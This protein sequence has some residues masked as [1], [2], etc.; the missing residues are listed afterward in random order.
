MQNKPNLVLDTLCE[1]YDLLLPW[2]KDLLSAAKKACKNVAI[3]TS[4]GETVTSETA[5][6]GKILW[7]IKEFGENRLIL[8]KQKYMC[9]SP[10]AILI[11]DW[12]KFTKPWEEAGGTAIKLKREWNKTGYTHDE[13]IDT[14]LKYS[15]LNSP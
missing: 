13:I 4:P 2:A 12:E 3:L 8:A 6:L 5:A 1:V 9:A 11:D 7:S 14:L 15:R 10:G